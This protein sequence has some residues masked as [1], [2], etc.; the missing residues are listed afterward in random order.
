MDIDPKTFAINNYALTGYPDD[1]RLVTKPTVV[2]ASKTITLSDAQR[3]G[4][5][6]SKID[7]DTDKATIIFVCNAGKVKF[8]INDAAQGGIFQAEVETSAAVKYVHTL[9]DSLWYFNNVSNNSA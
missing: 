8:Q 4:T 2:F 6:V 3:A 7:I 1:L 9:G 5:K